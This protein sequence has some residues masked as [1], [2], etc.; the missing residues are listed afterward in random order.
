MKISA[1]YNVL[2]VGGFF[3][4]LIL[5]CSCN[6]HL[7]AGLFDNVVLY[8]RF[9]HFSFLHNLVLHHF[10]LTL[11]MS[12]F[13]C[14]YCSMKLLPQYS[15]CL[16]AFSV[17]FF[18]T[19]WMVLLM[20]F[21]FLGI[22]GWSSSRQGKFHFGRASWWRRN[23]PRVQSFEQSPHK[24]VKFLPVLTSIDASNFTRAQE[25]I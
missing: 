13:C 8:K 10:I 15:I 20:I 23:N 17:V 16:F 12:S 19:W 24:F 14:K 11:T 22:L 4:L 7:I 6:V 3:G 9:M 2:L 1:A 5:H 18:S 25:R 21:S